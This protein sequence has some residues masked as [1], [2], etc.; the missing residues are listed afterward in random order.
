MKY[1]YEFKKLIILF[2]NEGYVVTNNNS[3]EKIIKHLAYQTKDKILINDLEYF[4]YHYNKL[5]TYYKEKNEEFLE[6]KIIY[7]YSPK[8][9]NIFEESFSEIIFYIFDLFTF[10]GKNDFLEKLKYTFLYLFPK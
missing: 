6:N 10:I 5:E 1:Y 8:D 9:E 7:S 4:L 3:Y 2:Q